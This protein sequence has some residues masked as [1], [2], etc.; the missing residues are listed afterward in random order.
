[1]RIF[2][3]DISH[4]PAHGPLSIHVW[5]KECPTTC[6]YFLQLCLDGFY[7][8]LIFHRIV[9]NFLIQTGDASFRQNTKDASQRQP[10][11]DKY[12][13][14][15]QASQAMERRQYELNSQ[16]RFN[17]RGQFAMALGVNDDNDTDA[18]SLR[19]L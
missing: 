15:H 4:D 2:S 14:Q 5:C 16:I 13:N 11:S 10:P 12:C 8:N 1:M 3:V 19:Q 17:H 9:P 7:D 6:R 18:E